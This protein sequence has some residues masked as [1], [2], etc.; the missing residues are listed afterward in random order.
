ME[1]E[2]KRRRIS[3]L[4]DEMSEATGPAKE[5]KMHEMMGVDVLLAM[6][7][8]QQKIAAEKDAEMQRMSE[9]KDAKMQRMAEE[10]DAERQ[11]M[12]EAKDAERQRMAEDKDAKLQQ[13]TDEKDQLQRMTEA[14]DAALQQMS[15]ELQESREQIRRLQIMKENATGTKVVR[16]SAIWRNSAEVEHCGISWPRPE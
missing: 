14:K 8:F 2:S 9:A 3:E 10:K 15:L 13:M 4:C 6:E 11:R 16:F 12:A 5:A 1:P 7:I